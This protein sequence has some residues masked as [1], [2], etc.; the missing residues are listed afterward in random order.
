MRNQLGV[1]EILK[2]INDIPDERTRQDALGTCVDNQVLVILLKYMFDPSIKLLL[3]HGSPPYNENPFTDQENNLYREFR[4][5]YVF[6]DDKL[7]INKL[8]RESIFVQFLE[9]ISKD[10]AKFIVGVKD[11]ECPY[12][13]ITYDLVMKT[14]PGLLPEKAITSPLVSTTLSQDGSG[15]PHGCVP[16]NETGKYTNA[17]LINHLRIAHKYT[18]EQVLEFR[19]ETVV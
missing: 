13:N 9:S 8:K 18:T 10:D 11:K 19:K 15:C 6:L 5:F 3:P 4:R 7:N 17:G 12:P 14:F 1:T 2:Q 16:K